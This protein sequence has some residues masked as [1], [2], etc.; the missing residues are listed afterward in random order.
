MG[1]GSVIVK[2]AGRAPDWLRYPVCGRADR[3]RLRAVRQISRPDITVRYHGQI[4]RRH[5][6]WASLFS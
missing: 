2:G 5:Q 6:T 3:V 4:S 1:F